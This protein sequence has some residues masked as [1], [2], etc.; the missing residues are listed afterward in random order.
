MKKETLITEISRSDKD[1]FSLV[2]STE[3]DVEEVEFDSI[4]YKKDF[5]VITM[6][7]SD[8]DKVLRSQYYDFALDDMACRYRFSVITKVADD[9]NSKVTE[10]TFKI[11]DSKE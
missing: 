4:V 7:T 2:F 9:L 1:T 6:L 8:A 3:G 5:V 10:V 11:K